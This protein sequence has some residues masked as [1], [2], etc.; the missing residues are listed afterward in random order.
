MIHAA[1]Y[2]VGVITGTVVGIVIDAH[3]TRS[4]YAAV[5]GKQL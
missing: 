5:E 2:L 1:I 4:A 3:I